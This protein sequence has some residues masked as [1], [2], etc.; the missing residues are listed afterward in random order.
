MAKVKED[1]SRVR[2]EIDGKQA[3]NQLGKLEMEAKQLTIDIKNA[4]KGTDEYISANKQLN[5]VKTKI[6]AVRKE[7]GLTGMTMT[8][9]TRYQRDLRNELVNTTT[10]GTRRYKELQMELQKVNATIRQQRAEL[11]GTAGFF[12]QI[13]KEIKA[14]GMVAL[15]YL[16][17]GAFLGQVQS[18]VQGSAR[19]SDELADVQ[20][21]TGLTDAELGKL[22]RTLKEM[23][24][25]TPRSELRGLA[26]IAGRLGLKGTKDIEGFV[27]AADKIN[28]ALG[29]VLGDPEKVMR[30][31]GKL[32]STF[33]ITQEFGI[34]DALL[35][36]GS[37]INE[38][39][40]A[41]TANEGYLVEF[42]KRMGGIAPLANISIENILGLGATLDSLGQTSEVSSTA[43]SK[44]FIGMAK[45][46]EA[47]AKQA[48]MPVEDFVKLLNED[49]NE[50]FL[51]VLEGVKGNSA[52]LVEL[53][54]TLGDVGQDGGRVVG[55]LGTLANNTE[56]L[57]KQQEISNK[58]FKEGTSV[59][60][61]FNL[62]NENMAANLAK[63]QKWLAGL[64]VNSRVME[65]L[66][67]FIGGWAKWLQMPISRQLENERI[68]LN[69]L[70]AQII[71]T[72]EGTEDRIKLINELKNKYPEL[73]KNINSETVTNQELSKAVK[74]VNEQL[75]NKIIIQ[76]EEEKIQKQ[77]K[78]VADQ[79]IKVAKTELEL[80]EQAV[81]LSEKYKFS[82][83]EGVTPL[84]Q[85]TDAIK[86]S[87]DA[88]GVS[89]QMM[90]GRL[91]ND[92]S[93]FSQKVNELTKMYSNLSSA[94]TFHSTIS[95]KKNELMEKLNISTIDMMTSFEKYQEKVTE[96][97]NDREYQELKNQEAE[98]FFVQQKYAVLEGE[99]KQHLDNQLI[100]T[101]QYEKELERI[102][103]FKKGEFAEIKLRFEL[104]K[105]IDDDFKKIID[106]YK[107][108]QK[109]LVNIQNEYDFSLLDKESQDIAKIEERFQTLRDKAQEYYQSGAMNQQEYNARINEIN[110][111]QDLYVQQKLDE[112]NEVIKEKRKKLTSD[113]E[114]DQME[115]F[116]KYLFLT[117]QSFD[118]RIEEMQKFGLD[119]VA[120]EQLKF[121]TLEQMHRDHENKKLEKTKEVNRQRL[122]DEIRVKQALI[123]I[124]MEYSNIAGAAID[125]VGRKGGELT[126]FQKVLA[127]AQIGIDTGASIMKAELVALN[128]ATAGG[129]AAPFIYKATKLS[130]I[131]SILTAAGR[132]K[133]LLSSSNDPTWGA[134]DSSGGDGPTPQQRRGTTAPKR[135]Y[136]T[137]GQ[138]S[139]EGLGFG[140]KY[141]EYVGFVHKRE[142]VIP[143]MVTSH[144]WVAN[145]LP[146]IES[147]RQEKMRGFATGGPTTPDTMSSS[148][149]APGMSTERMENLMLEMLR[150]MKVQKKTLRAYLVYNDLEE[151]RE[152]METLKSKYRA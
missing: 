121:D 102:Q 17:A 97:S 75:I 21:T 87:T 127:L 73:L 137:G 19:L 31:L 145:V 28:V 131:A 122:E 146:A 84:E 151:M 16:G 130:V 9:L 40:M 116:E 11:N 7:L 99:L 72:N 115:E 56:T 76:Q 74:A 45:N 140:D 49:A 26:E 82:L 38:L 90:R 107:N 71:T 119:S 150:E 64:F 124:T 6:S 35:K 30:E 142:Y 68:A 114:L 18:M 37:A 148:P 83:K 54:A 57:R 94:E 79:R 113:L 70:Y 2:L 128:A 96:A 46:A 92:V 118:A 47:F 108:L 144:P 134:S 126:A 60:N 5:E 36:V 93:N 12:N 29:D 123:E 10:A 129:P 141:G 63:V 101:E 88:Q 152:E 86:R 105:N 14:F 43:L 25:R 112:Q 138:T 81:A 120:L 42:T 3:I 39:G 20:K 98:I 15:G 4:K 147:I 65:G 44:L 22:N 139:D 110:A 34:E 80:R 48:Q 55:V 149:A 109:E 27:N 58:A 85:F 117:K 78:V 95:E 136:Y 111:L 67:A 13:G 91:F 59:V 23:D 133:S 104:S 69:S 103:G 89:S 61:E 100:S 135:S 106:Q 66:N 52:G 41:S 77:A 143:E 50:A 125:L 51:K 8:Q 53:A 132:A 24:T 32:T 33:G 62:K 1:K